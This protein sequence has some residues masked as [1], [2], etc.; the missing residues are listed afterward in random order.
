MSSIQVRLFGRFEVTTRDCRTPSGL[1][2]RKVQ[3]LLAYLLLS[4]NRLVQRE[5]VA[6]QLWGDIDPTRS[7]KYLRQTLWQLQRALTALDP[8]YGGHLLVVRHEWINIAPGVDLWVDTGQFDHVYRRSLTL[9]SGTA[10]TDDMRTVLSESVN[11]YRGE[12]LEGWYCDWV[13]PQ[14]DVYRS[15]LLLMLDKLIDDAEATGRWEIGLLH[16]RRAL[17]LDRANERAHVGIMRLHCLAGNRTAAL[18][19]FENCVHALREELGVEPQQQTRELYELIR[20]DGWRPQRPAP[21]PDP[22]ASL[23]D[24]N[25]S[26]TELRQQVDNHLQALGGHQA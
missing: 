9:T 13:T 16:G 25:R 6:E 7:K 10:L 11:L 3:E 21:R 8:E 20:T 14:Q 5:R 17:E 2:A 1:E 15:M 24:L 23:G 18:R 12:L 22:S 4:K 19:Q 26:L